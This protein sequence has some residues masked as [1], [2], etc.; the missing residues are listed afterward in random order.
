MAALPDLEEWLQDSNDALKIS[1]VSPSTSG[2]KTISTFHPKFTY[3]IFGEDE[4]IFGYKGLKLQLRY[5]AND[6]RPHLR[7][8]YSKKFNP[9]GDAE[10]LDIVGLLEEGQHLPKVAFVKGSDFDDS[11]K[12]LG[13]NWSPPGK[14]H[15]TIHGS[16]GE[17][18]IWEGNL[19]DP[20]V[21]QLNSRIQILV[22]L[23]IEGGSYIGSDPEGESAELDLSD[24]D[25]WTIFFLYRRQKSVDDPEKS[26]YTFV[27][28]A[29]IYRF[30]HFHPPTPPASPK[31]D[32]ELPRGDMEF[33]ELPCRSR[34]SQFMI[35][36]PFQGKGKG[37]LLY[38]T[39]FEHYHKHE[40]TY[41]ITVENPNEAFDD[42][43]DA[44]DLAFLRTMPE[45]EALH[46]DT[47]ITLPR[48]GPLPHLIVGQENLETIRLKA[49][50]APRQFSRVLEMHL[51]S[52]LPESVRP[53]MSLEDDV[54]VPTK[55]DKHQEKLWQL[56]VKQRLYRH[57]KDVLSQI[58][59]GERIDKL[60]ETLSSVE[61][62]YA[63]L[64]AAYERA[65]Q[66]SQ[67]PAQ[68]V[69]NGKRKL[70][71]SPSKEVNNS[72][73]ARVEDA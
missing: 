54:P 34:L 29:T 63:R 43:R 73:K 70:E 21:K 60:S 14:L 19:A 51:M 65:A 50:I 30:F 33:S 57:N 64:L 38:N 55:K 35:L 2:L 24:A 53:S 40:Q 5:R 58:E 12:Q 59:V 66:H 9:V 26:S 20:A 4:K 44:C 39:L 45:F 31:N 17:Y 3:P 32:W 69:A 22:P 25:R 72:K 8:S 61:L 13:D 46:L 48:S 10:P 11:S 47:D 42:L 56:V 62:E 52:Q 36:P 23:F 15:S 41:E 28:Y 6:M 67:A 1:L 7:V 68:A 71:A 49:K 16:D 18:E 37:A 27:G